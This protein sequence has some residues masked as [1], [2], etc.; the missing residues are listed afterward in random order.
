M[1]EEKQKLMLS[2]LVSSPELFTLCSTIIRPEYFDPEFRNTVRFMMKYS[3]EY[4]ALPDYDQ[5][6]A[7]TDI[8]LKKP[9]HS[10]T[11]DQI[12]YTAIEMESFCRDKA[13]ELAILKSVSI[14]KKD[15]V[16]RGL[17]LKTVTDAV[18]VSLHKVMGI[19]FNDDPTIMFEALKSKP[20]QPTGWTELDDILEGGLQE[21][22]LFLWGAGSGGGKSL[23]MQN[24][25][26]NFAEQ[27]V[28]VL[29]ISLELSPQVIFKRLA[30][31]V[32][33]IPSRE[34]MQR[35][36]EAIEK[37]KEAQRK[38]LKSIVIEQMPAGARP[39]D[40]RAYLKEFKLRKGWM[41]RL[42]VL[43]YLD[44]MYP[45]EKEISIGDVW[46]KDKMVAEQFRQILVDFDMYGT[47]ASQLNRSAVD[48]VTFN[49]SHIAG[50]ISKINTTDNYAAIRQSEQM[51]AKGE[52]EFQ[53]QKTRNSDGVG[54]RITLDYNRRS[55]RIRDQQKP[56]P[57]QP[58]FK[59]GPNPN[60]PESGKELIDIIKSG[61]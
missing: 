47:S 50:G 46:L 30:Q 9:D 39:M 16:D 32:T 25:A 37:I 24:L 3:E 2:Y 29:Y 59:N 17:I 35:S 14:L 55:L 49:H 52:I 4:D 58:K 54:K 13:I 34:I 36:S 43:D 56:N 41:P 61:G 33:E 44:L 28:S 51:R 40:I 48:E 22:E 15:D 10:L 23:V 11:D 31:M 57:L 5:I 20:K 6:S 12:L 7:E 21:K 18:Q 60:R 38:Y 19:D 1:N 45:N 27:G 53:L 26:L 42:L 8:V